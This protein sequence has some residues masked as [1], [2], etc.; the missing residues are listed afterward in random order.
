VFKQYF[1]FTKSAA[2]NFLIGL[3]VSLGLLIGLGPLVVSYGKELP[4]SVLSLVVLFNAIWWGWQIGFLSILA[5]TILGLA[6]F[7][8]FYNYQSGIK[9]F[10]NDSNI[11]YFFG[12][13]ASS[14]LAGYF[15]EIPRKKKMLNALS[16]WFLGHCLIILISGLHICRTNTEDALGFMYWE[17]SSSALKATAGLIITVAFLRFVEGREN[18]YKAS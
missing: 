1:A 14:L 3:V 2:L 11:G 5:Y 10:Y 18:F 17:L 16:I 12:L 4:F 7:E 15:A 8:I 9:Y 13:M 6:G